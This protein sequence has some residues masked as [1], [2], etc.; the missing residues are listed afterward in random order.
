MKKG[1]ST[2][3]FGPL[4]PEEAV[5]KMKE[6]GY[7]AA[8]LS[9]E[10]GKELLARAGGCGMKSAFVFDE[11]TPASLN[12]NTP[13]SVGL[14]FR[15]FLKKTGFSIP[16]AHLYFSLDMSDPRAADVHL[17]WVELYLAIGVKNIVIHAVA[18][19]EIPARQCYLGI[20]ENFKKIIARFEG[21]DAFLC[22]E[23]N[24][25]RFTYTV[26]QLL[27]IIRDAGNSPHFGICCDTGHLNMHQVK[28]LTPQTHGEFIRKAG[29][30]LHALHIANND[31]SSDM[32]CMP[33]ALKRS[34]GKTVDWQ[35]VM[36]A[37]REVG[38]NDLFNF[39]IPGESK[40]PL[41]IR[42]LK[43]DYIARLADYMLDPSHDLSFDYDKKK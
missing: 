29:S 38:S 16:Q 6:H 24:S 14:E 23:N 3:Y 32:H 31:G 25:S 18:P 7:T 12:G 34:T 4:S 35:E 22:I 41:P 36:V 21:T 42:E 30:R 43:I 17:R 13:R 37:L 9:F 15:E 33:F 28:G 1:I 26:D 11:N 2:G 20:V 5:W 39:E 8:E 19:K 10:H 40:A 27:H